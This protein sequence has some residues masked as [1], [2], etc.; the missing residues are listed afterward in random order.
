MGGEFIPWSWLSGPS[1]VKYTA[2][3]TSSAEGQPCH[4]LWQI[5]MDEVHGGT[6]YHKTDT[7]VAWFGPGSWVLASHMQ[8]GL[9]RQRSLHEIWH[10]SS[11]ASESELPNVAAFKL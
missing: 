9:G 8:Q 4:I 2:C 10:P 3:N 7:I 11:A 1:E 6:I 5:I